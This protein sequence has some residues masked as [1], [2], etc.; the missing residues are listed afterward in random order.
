MGIFKRTKNKQ[1]QQLDPQNVT[2]IASLQ[3]IVDDIAANRNHKE[4][5]IDIESEL[6]KLN[7]QIEAKEV[8]NDQRSKN[9]VNTCRHIIVTLQ[10]LKI[11]ILENMIQELISFNKKVTDIVG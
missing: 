9:I 1:V 7:A 2:A 8:K 4:N 5:L 10:G 6:L 11:A 3:T